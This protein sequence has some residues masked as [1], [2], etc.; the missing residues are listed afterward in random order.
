MLNSSFR[1]DQSILDAP[2]TTMSLS[3]AERPSFSSL[4]NHGSSAS[5]QFSFPSSQ[6]SKSENSSFGRPLS[7]TP[8]STC[9]DEGV[10]LQISNLDQWYDEANLRNYLMNQL[11]PITPI[12]SLSIETPSIAKVK[13]P[14]IQVNY[15]YLNF[16][17]SST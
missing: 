12:L 13:V 17:A 15:D 3:A 11:K 6:H 7:P 5:S 2:S 16:I 9:D 4:F 10:Y 14:S 1:S 8:S